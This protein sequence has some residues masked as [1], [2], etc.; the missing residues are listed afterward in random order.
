MC[1]RDIPA[2]TDTDNSGGDELWDCLM[3]RESER[4]VVTG[5]SHRLCSAAHLVPFRRGNKYIELLTR[6]RRYED[7]DDPI[8]DDVNGPRNALFVNLFLRIAIGSMRA[9]FLQTPNFILNPEHINS[10]YTGG[11]HIFLH[12]FA[13]PLELDQAVKAS[14]PHGQPIRLP[15]PMN[16]EIWPPHAIFAAYYGSGRVRAI[17]SMLDLM[18]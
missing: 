17:C 8:I 11:S 9:A 16:R 2:E 6:R 10:Q 4:C 15:E 5:T 18:I 1:K 7:E 12:Y 13:Q 3:E 14:I